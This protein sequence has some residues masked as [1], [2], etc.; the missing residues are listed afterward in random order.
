[1][2][3]YPT[4]IF[5]AAMIFLYGL[6][7]RA[8]DRSLLTAPMFFVAVGV[9]AG[10]AGLDLFS[11][12]TDLDAVHVL[13]EVT[14]VVVLFIDAS[15]IDL[16]KLLAERA[17]PLRLLLI[18]LPLTMLLGALLAWPLYPE[19]NIWLLLTMALILSPTDAAL[20]QAVILSS[21]VP[22][23]V[24]R[25]I[26]V[27][28]GLNDGIALP[29]ILACIAVLSPE[30]GAAQT[31]WTLF[32]LQQILL[33]GLVGGAVGWLGGYLVSHASARGWM[34]HSFQQ[35][36]SGSMAVLCFA[37]AE[38]LHGNG[39][40][41]AFAGGL[42]LGADI[43]SHSLRD[44]ILEFGEA[45]GQQLVLFVF[46]I[47]AMAMVPVSMPHWDLTAWIYALLSLSVI[48]LLPV[49]ICLVGSRLDLSTMLFIGWFG[50][51][52]I[53]SVL[54][55]LL[56]VH[57]LGFDGYE[58]ILSVIVLTVLLS[59]FLHGATAV[60]LSRRYARKAREHG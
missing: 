35:L 25:W 48:R 28:S 21:Q 55:L 54:Y 9:L 41:A 10:P 31:S 13:T 60:P 51:R 44:R 46:L 29:P 6:F 56:V 2:T 17:I 30:A 50:P 15:T 47:F 7:S 27:E 59:V 23:R 24:R 11:I 57:H 38:T 19:V 26:S 39:F 8:A 3:D 45:F 32:I 49:A 20:G 42:M 36:V 16:K 58:R 34:N 43:H 33:G 12:K 1:M 22:E 5:A 52:G 14:L 4:L 37:I 18:G 40:I 53:A